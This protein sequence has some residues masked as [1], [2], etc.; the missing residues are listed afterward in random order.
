MQFEKDLPA[1]W[2]DYVQHLQNEQGWREHALCSGDSSYA[3]LL[4]AP[5]ED[6][7]QRNKEFCFACPVQEDCLEYAV[8]NKERD[9]IWGGASEKD[10]SKLI[11]KLNTVTSR[12]TWKTDVPHI[13]AQEVREYIDLWRTRFEARK[14]A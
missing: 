13:V 10:R 8:I 14:T 6:D 2:D 12:A 9:G 4:F 5:N 7:Q 11:R 3:R 1:S